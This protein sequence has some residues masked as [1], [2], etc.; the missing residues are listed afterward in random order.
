[1][2]HIESNYKFF[3]DSLVYSQAQQLDSYELMK[4][5]ILASHLKLANACDHYE[6]VCWVPEHVRFGVGPLGITIWPTIGD[7]GKRAQAR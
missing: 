5:N 3:L 1:M 2:L 6:P 4:H 7:L